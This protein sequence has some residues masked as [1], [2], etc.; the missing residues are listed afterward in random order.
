M[1]VYL[2]CATT[3]LPSD[4]SDITSVMVNYNNHQLL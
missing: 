3:Q 1:A 2:I 4:S